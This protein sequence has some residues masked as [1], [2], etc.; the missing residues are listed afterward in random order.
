MTIKPSEGDMKAAQTVWNTDQCDKYPIDAIAKAIATA[1][2]EERRKCLDIC[3]KYKD[4][5]GFF[6]NP[7]T[8]AA[9]AIKR[10]P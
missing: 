6:G 1:R 8:M 2:M 7:A 9:E 10:L 5:S 3:A 4:N